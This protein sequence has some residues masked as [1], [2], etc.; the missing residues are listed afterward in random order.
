HVTSRP[1]PPVRQPPDG[2]PSTCAHASASALRRS[3]SAAGARASPSA[4][5]RRPSVTYTTHTWS[6][7]RTCCTMT[8]AQPHTSSSG[9]GAT[10]ST[11]SSPCADQACVRDAALA[12]RRAKHHA[13]NRSAE[14]PAAS[15]Y[16][17]EIAAGDAPLPRVAQLVERQP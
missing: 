12:L 15:L 6:P 14:R 8:P 2:T 3:A 7:L 1:A 10:T 4:R 17:I 11:L 13:H 16:D 9:C 5:D